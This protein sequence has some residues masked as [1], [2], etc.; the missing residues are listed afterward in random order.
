MQCHAPDFKHHAGSEDDR[1]VKGVHAGISCIA[2][3]RPH[4]GETRSSCVQCH[5]SLTEEQI[6]G[7]YKNPHGFKK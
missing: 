3:H 7:I 1:T 5:P 6:A 4:S 2:C